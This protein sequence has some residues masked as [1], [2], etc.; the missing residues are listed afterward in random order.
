MVKVRFKVLLQVPFFKQMDEHLV[1]AMCDRLKP[2]LYTENSLLVR[3]GDPVH[4]ILFITRGKV[5]SE[6]TD[7]DRIDF[8]SSIHLEDGDLCGEELLTWSLDPSTP[9]LP[10]STRTVKA[11]T[12]VQAFA[13]VAEDLM[14][15]ACQFRHLHSTRLQH[16]FR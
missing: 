4:E 13:L 8:Y 6:T 1:D 10:F 9:R 3:E 12:H 5:L 15:V 2:V 14:F 16:T 11:A 7:G